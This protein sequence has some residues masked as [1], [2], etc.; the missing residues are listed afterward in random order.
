M[1][2][3]YFYPLFFIEI[4]WVAKFVQEPLNTTVEFTEQQ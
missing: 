2:S 1:K 4:I 3:Y